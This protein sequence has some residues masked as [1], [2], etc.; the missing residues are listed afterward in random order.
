[1][2]KE[3][4]SNGLGEL[5]SVIRGRIIPMLNIS[6]TVP[7]KII[8]SSNDATLL[9]LALNKSRSL[10]SINFIFDRRKF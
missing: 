5:N 2:R 6:R 9:D 8:T 3:L 7:T 1:L 4:A 10:T